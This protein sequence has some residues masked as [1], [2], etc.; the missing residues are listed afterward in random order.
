MQSTLKIDLDE[1]EENISKCYYSQCEN[2]GIYQCSSC[3]HSCCSIHCTVYEVS[4]G[5]EDLKVW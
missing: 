5:F 2:D 3:D 4:T 1:N